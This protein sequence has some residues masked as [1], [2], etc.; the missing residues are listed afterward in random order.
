MMVSRA[1]RPVVAWVST[2]I[3]RPLSQTETELSACS[4]HGDAVAVPGHR[5]VDR[6]V[7]DLVDQVMETALVGAPDVHPGSSSDRLQAL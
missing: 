3:P 5:L 7:D 4:P 2:G 6:V 1:G